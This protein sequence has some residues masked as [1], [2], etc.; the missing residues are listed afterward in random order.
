MLGTPADNLL[1][2]L[3][4]DDFLYGDAGADTFYGGDGNDTMFGGAGGD[5]FYGSGG[6]RDRV[7]YFAQTEGV[8]LRIGVGTA[9][10]GDATGDFISLSTEGIEGSNVGGDVIFGSAANNFLIGAGG[11]DILSGGGGGDELDGG[12]GID[13]AS[14][15]DATAGV[16]ADLLANIQNTGDAFGDSYFGIENLSGTMFADALLGSEGDNRIEGREGGDELVGRGGNDTLNGGVGL[17]SLNGSDGD[18]TYILDDVTV[19][20]SLGTA[21]YDTVTE[22]FAD[23]GSDLVLINANAIQGLALVPGYTLGTNVENATAYG[24][25][26]FRLTGNLSNNA[27]TGNTAANVLTGLSGNDRLD[28]GE[29][30]DELR[31]GDGNDTYVLGDI[32][33]PDPNAVTRYDTVVEAANGGTDT[34]LIMSGIGKL[35]YTLDTEVENGSVLGN[36]AFALTGNALRNR[37]E[38]NGA[39]NTLNGLG[40]ADVLDGD[41]G[42]DVL[43]GGDGNDLYILTDVWG[44]GPFTKGSYDTVVELAGGG[45]D[46]IRVGAAGTFRKY[47]LGANIENGIIAEGAS[48]SL[49]GTEFDNSLTGN[50]QQNSLGGRGGS[51]TLSG[52]AGNDSLNGGSGSDVLNGGAGGD[53]LNGGGG[54]DTFVYRFISDSPAGAPADGRDQILDFTA[55][56]IIDLSVIDA[57]FTTAGEQAFN[58]IGGSAFSAEGQ[59]RVVQLAAGAEIQINIS[60]GQP[61]AEMLILLR[62]VNAGAISAASFDL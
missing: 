50:G 12:E 3:D 17:D 37:L 59:I 39:E 8:F 11:D 61:G 13:E 31:G 18:D 26:D 29:G 51:D 25:A 54:S 55:G 14:Y 49:F 34:L 6:T 23:G 36:S 46:T 47:T 44:T 60:N 33:R 45:T 9:I 4:G 48:F 28:G 19:S 16:R 40:G 35:G 5:G 22:S 41:G 2:G 24:T 57:R 1:Q 56:D 32:F 42:E 43:A 15:L 58:F 27:L 53:R 62:G 30:A 10:G 21:R 20:G 52:E 7:S 38:G